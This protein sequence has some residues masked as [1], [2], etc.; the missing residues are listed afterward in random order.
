[1][2]FRMT[3]EDNDYTE[4]VETFADNLF[5]KL[6]WFGENPDEM[7]LYTGYSTRYTAQEDLQRILNPNITTHLTRED[8]IILRGAIIV[9]WAEYVDKLHK[10]EH[11]DKYLRDN[12]QVTVGYTFE[13]K[14]ENGEVVYYFTTNNSILTQ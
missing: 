9:K 12:F 14:W 6:Y 1:M 3:V 8:E 13:D 10:N 4:L 11:T 7:N 2:I 5:D